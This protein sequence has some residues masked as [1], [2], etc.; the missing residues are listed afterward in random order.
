MIFATVIF[1]LSL[2]GIAALFLVKYW[3][4]KNQRV[5][6][7][8]IRERVD[9]HAHELKELLAASKVE[10]AKLPLEAAHIAHVLIHALALQAARLA[11]MAEIQAHRLADF[12]SHKH[13]FKRREPRSEFLKKMSEHSLRSRNGSNGTGDSVKNDNGL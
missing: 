6:A 3:E 13:H 1:L 4:E 10:L 11:R 2:L 5:L 8:N 7:L 9:E 12:V